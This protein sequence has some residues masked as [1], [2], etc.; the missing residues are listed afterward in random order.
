MNRYHYT[1]LASRSSF[2]ASNGDGTSEV[3]FTGNRNGHIVRKIFTNSRERW[4]QQNVSGAFAELRKLVPTHPPDKKLSKNEILRMAI[5]YLSNNSF[6]KLGQNT[7]GDMFPN[8]IS[9]Q[10]HFIAHQ[11]TG[12]AKAT[13]HLSHIVNGQRDQRQQ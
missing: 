4:R 1:I 9:V 2:N 12:M 8:Q 10:V 11:C 5:R 6:H 13:K 7:A 3:S